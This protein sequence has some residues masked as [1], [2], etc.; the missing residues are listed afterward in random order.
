MYVSNSV[1]VLQ[2]HYSHISHLDECTQIMYLATILQVALALIKQ[3]STNYITTSL[4]TCI[5]SDIDECLSN[6]GSCHHNCHNVDGS[7]TC[8]CN[9]GYQ[10]TSDG[11]TCEGIAIKIP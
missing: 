6:N 3:V 8:F 5:Y 11:H 7:Y 1:D 4:C 9:Y 2:I 10:L